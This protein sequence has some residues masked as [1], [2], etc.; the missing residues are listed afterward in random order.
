MTDK[1]KRQKGEDRYDFL[2]RRER[3]NWEAVPRLTCCEAS[4]THPVVLFRDSM[5]E[6]RAPQWEAKVWDDAA[7]TAR[8]EMGQKWYD[9][10]PIQFCPYCG[11][12][13]PEMVKKTVL[14]EPIQVVDGGYCAT[15][16]ERLMACLCWPLEAGYEPKP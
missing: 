8:H 2:A 6:D 9:Y 7:P 14:P 15:C 3:E 16:K 4:R 12:K 11:T 1:R 10:P 5:D 13:A